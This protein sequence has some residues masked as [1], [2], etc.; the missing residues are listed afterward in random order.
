M[1]NISEL[2]AAFCARAKI[3][4]Q[5]IRGTTNY[6]YFRNLKV[7]YMSYS[8]EA[9]LAIQKAVEQAAP[10]VDLE[11]LGLSQRAINKLT[12]AGIMTM[13]VLVKT[14]QSTLLNLPSFGKRSLMQLLKAL[15]NYHTLKQ[16]KTQLGERIARMK[17]FPMPVER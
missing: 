9:L 12:E 16:K 17:A 15:A 13:D 10:I 3:I 6:S 7:L 11:T 14:P 2:R 8:Q 5:T 4:R 1:Y